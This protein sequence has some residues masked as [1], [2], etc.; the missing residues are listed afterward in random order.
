MNAIWRKEWVNEFESPW[1]LF[2]KLSLANVVNRDDIL[3]ILGSKDVK[4][5]KGYMIGNI[6]REFFDLSGFDEEL[7]TEVFNYKFVEK[8]KSSIEKIISPLDYFGHS[9]SSS[10]FFPQLRW[11]NECLSVGHHSWLHQFRLIEKCPY[12]NCP[13]FESCPQCKTIFPFLL[14][15]ERM[16]EAFTC[17]C[18]YKLVDFS[19]ELWNNWNTQIRINDIS[20][21]NWLSKSRSEESRYLFLPDQC[22]INLVT[23]SSPKIATEHFSYDKNLIKLDDL[24][25]HS[26]FN[27]ELYSRNINIFHTVDRYIRKTLL[28]SHK[29][30]IHQFWNLLK[31][32]DE[33]F[34]T[35]CPYAY[36]YVNWRKTLLKLEYFHRKNTRGDDISR[37]K[38]SGFE[39]ATDFITNE[40]KTLFEEF[41]TQSEKKRGINKDAL[42]WVHDQWTLRFG[43]KLFYAWLNCA[44]NVLKREKRVNWNDV[45]QIVSS[46]Q[47]KLA[48]K[49]TTNHFKKS[50]RTLTLELYV[51]PEV[52]VYPKYS[53]P[54]NTMKKRRNISRMKPFTPLDVAINYKGSDLKNYVDAY[55]KKYNF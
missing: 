32:E 27:K 13:L 2:E 26:H 33:E 51:S 50:E 53:C 37:T 44:E 48:F 21:I 54:N 25:Y 1:S 39:L 24:S 47:T 43:I 41:I 28:K 22:N 45:Q 34:P 35:I 20:V 38:K 46:V 31:N 14:S 8:V 7:L 3:K 11:C 5:I 55:V 17:K 52:M 40:I 12:H 36:A 19:N 15:N 16:Q 29:H 4:A 18:G 42:F 30:C 49:Y 10:W 6:R 23:E 9:N